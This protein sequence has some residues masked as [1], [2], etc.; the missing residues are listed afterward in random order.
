MQMLSDFYIKRFWNEETIQYLCSGTQ[1]ISPGPTG[2][3]NTGAYKCVIAT[4]A[5][6][7]LFL[8]FLVLFDHFQFL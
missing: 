3:L 5:F 6:L 4:W 8:L 7:C 1:V 2:S